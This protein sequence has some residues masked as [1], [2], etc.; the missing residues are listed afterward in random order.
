MPMNLQIN[1][2]SKTNNKLAIAV[3]KLDDDGSVFCCHR[4]KATSEKFSSLFL[5]TY[6]QIDFSLT[7][8][9]EFPKLDA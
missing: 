4:G 7:L 6:W 1:P 8:D 2:N 3:F 5:T 9:K